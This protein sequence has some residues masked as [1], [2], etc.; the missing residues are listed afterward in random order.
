MNEAESLDLFLDADVFGETIVYYPA[1]DLSQGKEILAVV[2]RDQ[3]TIASMVEAGLSLQAQIT[4][5]NHDTSG[6]TAVA[7]GRDLALVQMTPGAD[8][9]LVRVV[10]LISQDS[11]A[12]TLG[13]VR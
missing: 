5:A 12:W 7:K 1:G 6:V 2:E 3:L 8:P 13:V 9:E 10:E 4:I 11:G